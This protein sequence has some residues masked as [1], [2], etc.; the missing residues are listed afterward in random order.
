MLISIAPIFMGA[1]LSWFR[2][3]WPLSALVLIAG[4]AAAVVAGFVQPIGI[5]SVAVVTLLAWLC[6]Q[7][8]KG[9]RGVVIHIL[10]FVW[11]GLLALHLLP[12]FQN[13]LLIGPVSF[14]PDAIPFKMYFNFDKA[15]IGF[16]LILLYVPICREKGVGRS[17]LVGASG[18]MLGII[19][20]LPLALWLGAV[21][22]EPKFPDGLWLWILDNLLVALT[23]EALFRGFLQA[24][25]SR[26]LNGT[27]GSAAMAIAIAA[28]AFGLAHYASGLP[29]ILLASLAGLAYG[30]AYRY[31]GLLASVLA[32]FGLNLFH[33]LLFTYPLLAP[34]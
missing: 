2:K 6:G 8:L 23:E 32:H 7:T 25:L 27:G 16:A 14:T 11:A 22:W 24:S 34:H 13:P 10:F 3:A 18:A 29:M 17:L 33:I 1:L 19:L 31:G 20:T 21:R 26:W 9:I 15:A 30:L 4:Y 12:G 5:A 28:I